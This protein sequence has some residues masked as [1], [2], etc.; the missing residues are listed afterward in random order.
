VTAGLSVTARFGWLVGG[1]RP[2]LYLIGLVLLATSGM[3]LI[4]MVVDLSLGSRDWQAFAWSALGGA[5]TALANVGPG[6]GDTIGPSG[7]FSTLP[8]LAKWLLSFG[9]LLGRLE[10]FTV[11]I[12]FYPRF[13]RS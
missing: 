8:D 9:M 13:W 5:V 4:P 12:L 1:A 11:L 3:M 7:N 6:L 10:L 2:V